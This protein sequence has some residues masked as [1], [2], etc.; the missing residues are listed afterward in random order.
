MPRHFMTKDKNKHQI[1]NINLTSNIFCS[2][3]EI[4]VVFEF[5]IKKFTHFL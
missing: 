1:Q 5:K 4:F 3:L 2:S